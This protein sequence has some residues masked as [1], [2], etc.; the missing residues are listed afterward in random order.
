[1]GM[2]GGGGKKTGGKQSGAQGYSELPA[3]LPGTLYDDAVTVALRVYEALSITGMARVDLLIDEKLGKIYFNEVNPLPGSLYAHN[4]RAAGVPTI[5]LVQELI[6]YAEARFAERTAVD[7]TF[8]SS[9]L[10]QF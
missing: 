5:T 3:V 8:S 2:S 10:Q 1:M 9:F 4:W 6:A 7:T